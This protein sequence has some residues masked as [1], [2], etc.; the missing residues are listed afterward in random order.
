MTETRNKLRY[1]K[2]AIKRSEQPVGT[3]MSDVIRIEKQLEE[4]QITLYGDPVKRRLDMDQPLSPANRLGSIGYEQKYSTAAPTKTH[5]DSYEIAK[6]D[7]IAMKIKMET[8][9]NQDMKKLEKK[10]I[11]TGAPYTPGRGYEYKN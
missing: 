10:L 9:Y 6:V 3:M 7:I 5:R 1:I 11:N 8:I 2:A 4:V